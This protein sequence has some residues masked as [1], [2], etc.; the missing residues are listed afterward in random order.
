MNYKDYNDYELL[1]YV[2]E[3]SEEATEILYQKYMPLITSLS[4]KMYRYTS[5]NGIEVNDLVQEGLLGLS[6]AIREYSDSMNTSFYTFAK[7]CIERKIIT[8]VV[9][10]RR[11]KHK[12]L[13]DSIPLDSNAKGKSISLE[14][15]L[16][17]NHSNP[18]HVLMDVETYNEVVEQISNLLTIFEKQV[19]ELRVSGLSYKEIAEILDCEAKA[20]D[21][22]L[23]RIKGKVRKTLPEVINV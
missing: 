6:R 15:F 7:T 2:Q 12:I 14:E 3:N 22:C 8:A 19:F 21:N 23:Q 17:D 16:G 1:S 10:T 4:R 9:A 13:N 11:L 18:E 5:Q 20:I